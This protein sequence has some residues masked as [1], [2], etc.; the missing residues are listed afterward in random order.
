MVNIA[1]NEAI[2]NIT[3]AGNNGDLRDP[4]SFDATD[5]QIRTWVVESVQTGSVTN[6][7]ADP[8]V[9]LGDFSDFVV[10]R[11]ASSEE[12]P[13]NRIFLRPKATYG[14]VVV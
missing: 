14:F 8:N 9:T 11:F 2:V 4:V 3:W 12:T 7:T 13:Y 5:E 1:A 6:I 10:D